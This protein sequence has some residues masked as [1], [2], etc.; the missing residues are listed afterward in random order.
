MIDEPNEPQGETLKSSPFFLPSRACGGALASAR[1][2]TSEKPMA[3]KIS[4][5]ENK[6]QRKDRAGHTGGR[7]ALR[8]WAS[9]HPSN[10]DAGQQIYK[11]GKEETSPIKL[12]Y[13]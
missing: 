5:K 1:R 10:K 9:Q 4:S 6:S 7:P 8:G 2:V 12:N 11:L 3:P 13:R